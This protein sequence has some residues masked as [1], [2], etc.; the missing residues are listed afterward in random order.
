MAFDDFR[1]IWDKLMASPLVNRVLIN[2]T[3]DCY[4]M[5][6]AIRYLLY[7][8]SH[9]R[10]YVAMT[11]NAGAL[12]YIPRIDELVISFNGGTKEAYEYTVGLPFDETVERI[13]SAYHMISSQVRHA[14]LHCLVWDGNAGTEQAL[15][16]LWHDFPGRVRVSYKYD[17][18]HK[19]DHTLPEHRQSQRIPCDYLGMLCVQPD[20]QVIACAH[21][22]KRET[23]FGNLLTGSVEDVMQHPARGEMIERH[24]RFDFGGLCEKCNYNT[25]VGGRVAYLK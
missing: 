1:T 23:N 8:E 12:S 17:N 13:R 10:K 9:K 14:E 24:R 25:P 7:A 3:G 18:Q 21:D 19:A 2:N 6:D 4:V 20:G 5:D 16:E 22:F 15:L 11:T